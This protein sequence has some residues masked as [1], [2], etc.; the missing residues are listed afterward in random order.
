M[1]V[2]LD[3]LKGYMD[4]FAGVHVYDGGFRLPYYGNPLNDWLLVEYDH[5]HREFISKLLPKEIQERYQK[6]ER[7][8]YLPTLRGVIG[9]V[10]VN[11]AQEEK[12]KIAI[13]RDRLIETKA[14]ED[15]VG[16]VRYAFDQ[17]AY[18][19]AM[20]AYLQGQK[21]KGTEQASRIIEEIE[22]VL[23]DYRDK[24][25]AEHLSPSAKGPPE[26]LAGYQERTKRHARATLDAWPP[27]YGWGLGYCH[28]ARI[29]QTICMA[30]RL[31]QQV[32]S[33]SGEG[34]DD[35]RNHNQNR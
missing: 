16:V 34:R 6:T 29:A 25:P 5:S 4:R 8:R 20:R 3:D 15:L 31:D 27:G 23:D 11:T 30:G 7:L 14:Y 26:C 1:G 32:A 9:V 12:L 22:D 19:E 2:S 24:I 18:D 28:P 35:S 21:D 33:V 13:T 10:R 17:Y